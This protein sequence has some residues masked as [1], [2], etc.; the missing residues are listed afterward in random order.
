MT[1]QVPSLV[2]V[3]WP[4]RVLTVRL[5]AG[6]DSV[7]LYNTLG[8]AVSGA[9]GG[10]SGIHYRSRQGHDGSSLPAP[11]TQHRSVLSARLRG[12]SRPPAK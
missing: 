5:E 12:R 7:I 10:P 3:P 8:G 9:D 1:P 4:K 6:A 11:L 2:S